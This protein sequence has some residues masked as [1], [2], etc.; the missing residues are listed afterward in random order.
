[1]KSIAPTGT[2]H[3][4]ASIAMLTL[5]TAPGYAEPPS[6]AAIEELHKTLEGKHVSGPTPRGCELL[7]VN[8]AS[9]KMPMTIAAPPTDRGCTSHFSGDW[10]V[11]DKGLYCVQAHAPRQAGGEWQF[12]AQVDT[13]SDGSMTFVLKDGRR[14][15]IR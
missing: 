6:A 14:F 2:R 4:L 7:W 13:A 3:V 1:M 10:T 8:D 12:C 5:M 15:S 11:N 9:G